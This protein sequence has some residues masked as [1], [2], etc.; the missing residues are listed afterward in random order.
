VDAAL[1]AVR[2][3]QPAV[4]LHGGG[5][6]SLAA[7]VEDAAGLDEAGLQQGGEG[8]PG[9]QLL[10]TAHLEG[11]GVE[12]LWLDGVDATLGQGDVALLALDADPAAVQPPGHGRG[13]AAA[14][15]GV[16]DHVAR[17]A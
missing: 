13:G 8:H 11:R 16:E 6:I 4:R 9:R 5:A 1:E 3:A 12:E 14:Q 15:E 17:P 2:G 10:G 7:E